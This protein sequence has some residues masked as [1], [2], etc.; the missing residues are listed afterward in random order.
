MRATRLVAAVTAALV[1]VAPHAGAA[2]RVEDASRDLD[3]ARDDLGGARDR[4]ATGAERLAALR[5]E[6]D[7]IDARLRTAEVHLD[8][9]RDELAAAEDALAEAAAEQLD[10]ARTLAEAGRRLEA[11]VARW[12]SARS[13]LQRQVS[14]AYKHGAPASSRTLVTGL[15]RSR[16][17]HDV[18]RTVRTVETLVERERRSVEDRVAA[19][20][21]SAD[22]RAEVLAVRTEAR[23]AEQAAAVERTRVA[24]LAARQAALVDSIAV[25]RAGRAELVAEL[26]ADQEATAALVDELERRVREL[27]IALADAWM[28]D[29][30]SI[31]FDGPTPAW[32]GALPA[33]GVPWAPAVAGAA[34]AG[35]VDARLLAALVWTE[36]AFTPS[37]VSHAGAIGLAQLMPGTAAGLGVD[38]WAPLENLTGGAR[39]LRS[40][41]QRFGRVDLALAAYNAGP[42]RVE[43]AGGEVPAIVETQLYVV[44]VLERYERLAAAG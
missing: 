23:R 12:E 16:D 40:Q 8:R 11:E 4:L 14:D 31:P 26:A 10:A 43:A 18:A 36:S 42:A 6:L 17:M 20:R 22:A 33:R 34:A 5:T 24:D 15:L 27:Q 9:T 3:Q 30:A 21:E 35:G 1:L 13:D 37:A 32:A 44:R 28:Q 29:I 7:E 39:Y 2:E 38:P 19:T 25:E 41:L